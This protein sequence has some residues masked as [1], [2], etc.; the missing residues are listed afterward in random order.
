MTSSSHISGTDRIYEAAKKL[1]L[2][3]KTLILNLQGDE[4]FIPSELVS[5]VIGDYYDNDCDVITVSTPI[6]SDNELTNPNCV[7]VETDIKNYAVNFVRTGNIK[8]PRRHLGIYGYSFKTLS[9]LIKLKP[10]NNELSLNLEQLRFFENNYSIFVSHFDKEIPNGIDTQDDV[11][12]ALMYLKQWIFIKKLINNSLRLNSIANY[13]IELTDKND[14]IELH[15]FIK[16]KNLPVLVIGE[17]TNVV[18]P[19]ILKEL[20]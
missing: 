6:K 11:D 16:N 5:K 20:L 2:N 14:F 8:N 12:N 4:P 9:A 17:G 10:T 3:D 18:L 15:K 19:D 1:G 13:F 7:L